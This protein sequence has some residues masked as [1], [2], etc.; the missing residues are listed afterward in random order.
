MLR[1]PD[2]VGR[3][4][5]AKLATDSGMKLATCSGTKLATFSCGPERVANMNPE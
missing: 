3:A 5:R 1:I 4:F 2:Q